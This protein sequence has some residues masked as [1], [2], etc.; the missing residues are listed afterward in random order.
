MKLASQKLSLDPSDVCG[1]LE[2]AGLRTDDSPVY[3][4][5]KSDNTYHFPEIKANLSVIVKDN[6]I[7]SISQFS[8]ELAS[9]HLTE[10][11]FNEDGEFGLIFDK[12]N[13]FSGENGLNCDVG[14]ITI[15]AGD[16]RIPFNVVR[17]KKMKNNIVHY[18]EPLN[19]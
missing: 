5:T 8:N 9:V 14:E 17:V 16:E 11:D 13:F 12:T 2:E 4:F 3:S 7:Q 18:V 15:S 10:V 19:K 1:R 6:N